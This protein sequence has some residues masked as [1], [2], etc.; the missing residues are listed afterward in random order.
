MKKYIILVKNNPK[1][2]IAKEKELMNNIA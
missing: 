2:I 1:Q